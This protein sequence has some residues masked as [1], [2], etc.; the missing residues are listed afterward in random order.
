MAAPAVAKP[1]SSKTQSAS[2]G[3]IDPRSVTLLSA[4]WRFDFGEHPGAEQPGFDDANWAEVTVPHSW[5][6]VGYYLRPASASANRPETV[7]KAQGIGWYRLA[8]QADPMLRGKHIWLE[9]DAASRIASIWLN[10]QFLG[11][12][13]GGYSRFRLDATKAL[14]P[15]G[16]N[17]LAVRVDNSKPAP[18]SSTADILP[19]TGDF[20][21]PGGL[22]RPVRI[23]GT[24]DVHFDMMDHGGSGIR[25]ITRSLDIG[26]ALLDVE[27]ALRSEKGKVRGLRLETR[28]LDVDGRVAAQQLQSLSF[29]SGK[30]RALATLQVPSARLWQGTEDPYLYR[31]STRVLDSKGRVLDSV[32][33]SFGIRRMQFDAKQGF[34]LNGK[35]YRLRGVGYHQDREDKGWAIT[36]ADVEQ[37]VATMREMG[38]N[39]IRLTHYQHGQTI[40]DLADRYGIVLWDEV[41]L[42]SAWTWGDTK[43]ATAGLVAN[44]RQQLSELIRQNGNHASV[45]SWGIA[46]EVDFGNSLPAFLASFKGAP[47]DPLPLLKELNAAAKAL[48]PSR[49]TALAT[50]CEGRLFAPGVEVPVTAPEA[51][52]GGA[53]RYFGWYYGKPEEI[54][55]SLDTLHAQRPDQPLAVTEY[56]AGGATTIHTDNVLGGPVDSRGR[57]QP[58][59]YESYVHERNWAQLVDRKYLWATWLWVGFDFAST[60]RS[61]GDAQD[62]NTKGLVN[63][64]HKLRKDAYYFYKANWSNEPTVYITGRRYVDRAYVVTDVRVY[65]NAPST[66]LLLNGKSLGSVSNCEQNVCI[67]RNVRLTVGANALIAKGSID[68]AAVEDRVE[69]RLSDEVARTIRIDAG[70][71]VAAKSATGTYGSDNFFDG[72]AAGSIVEPADYGKPIK[73]VSIAGTL[74][75]A[76]AATYREG[77]F[78]YRIPLENGRYRVKLTFVEPSEAPK[79]YHFSVLADENI[80]IADLDLAKTSPAARTAVERNFL[81]AVKNGMLDLHFRPIVGKAIVSAI[82]IVR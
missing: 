73:P 64:D 7:N 31:L 16:A 67:W 80:V 5:N 71:L 48:D 49:P 38:V 60:V 54:G 70:A 74:D 1:V 15:G 62:V 21:V 66:E 20:F 13:K 57:A 68:G 63:F 25:A 9:F 46:N 78:H 81:V 6:R 12:H 42:V 32:E 76:I 44:A 39:S 4:G 40:H 72:G 26:A 79:P 34:L 55:S 52:L 30:A 23:V 47:P 58:E 27:A 28:L 75:S 37:D 41:P 11:E 69:W 53:N 29:A 10:G 17:I 14:K 59:E 82:E 56:G 65:S 45:A 61:E 35:P 8:F 2:A 77:N 3:D 43:E 50:C 22:Y 51:D 33:Q 19:L 36:P 24:Q 18:G